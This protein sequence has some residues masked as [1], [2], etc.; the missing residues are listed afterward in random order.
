MHLL[1]SATANTLLSGFGGMIIGALAM[2]WWYG[3]HS[4][5]RKEERDFDERNIY[6]D[7]RKRKFIS[8]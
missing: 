1:M 4:S 6:S 5:S 7:P 2:A 8:K 3:A